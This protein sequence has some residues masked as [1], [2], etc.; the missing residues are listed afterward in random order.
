MFAV[1]A[2]NPHSFAKSRL[3]VAVYI[4]SRTYSRTE[5]VL[6]QYSVTVLSF[7]TIAQYIQYRFAY[8]S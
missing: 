4:F 2:Y 1:I 3:L 5:M 8:G 7:Q 6:N